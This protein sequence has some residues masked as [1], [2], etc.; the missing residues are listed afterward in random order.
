MPTLIYYTGIKERKL[1]V[2]HASR[3]MQNRFSDVPGQLKLFQASKY[4]K[5]PA[6]W[7]TR[8]LDFSRLN[9]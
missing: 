8:N 6:C 3:G 2:S 1:G 5:N 9:S 7:A 4:V